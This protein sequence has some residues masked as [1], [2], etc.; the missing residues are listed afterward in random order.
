M[1]DVSIV[2]LAAERDAKY[3]AVLEA[4]GSDRYL[5]L[6]VRLVEAALSPRLLPAA[7]GQARALLREKP[8]RYRISVPR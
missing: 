4:L 6:L 3:A 2:T 7:D 1:G 8:A 5:S